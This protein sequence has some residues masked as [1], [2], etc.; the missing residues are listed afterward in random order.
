MLESFSGAG[1][2]YHTRRLLFCK[3]QLIVHPTCVV[4]L[5]L[6]FDDKKCDGALGDDLLIREMHDIGPISGMFDGNGADVVVAVE[7]KKGILVQ[8]PGFG[9]LRRPK[10]YMKRVRFLKVFNL[11]KVNAGR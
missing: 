11:H 4:T 8:I 7:I 3:E 9:D 2:L 6:G 5:S 1:R 10:L